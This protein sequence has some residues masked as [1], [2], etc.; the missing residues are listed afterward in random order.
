MKASRRKKLGATLISLTHKEVRAW[1][2]METLIVIGIVMVLTAM[3]G[4]MGF[5]FI[6]QAKQA[7]ARSQIEVYSLALNG[8]YMDCRSYPTQT[9]GLSALWQK[10]ASAPDGW[11]GPYINKPI[12]PDPWGAPYIYR[13]PGPNNLPFEIISYGS[14][15]KEGGSGNDR[16]IKSDE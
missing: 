12:G 16:D 6:D 8:Y 13:N 7:T 4:V 2:F 10:P 15:G 9:D 1:T 5:R 3:V 14:D 11:T